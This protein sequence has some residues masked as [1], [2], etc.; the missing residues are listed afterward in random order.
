MTDIQTYNLTFP[1]IKMYVVIYYYN[2]YAE[3]EE[4]LGTR[5]INMCKVQKDFTCVYAV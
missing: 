2:I 4:I 3:D 5:W 1:E